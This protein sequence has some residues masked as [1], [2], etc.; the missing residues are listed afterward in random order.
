MASSDRELLALTFMGC[1]IN[2]QLCP[3][4]QYLLVYEQ[5]K[6]VISLVFM[7]FNDLAPADECILLAVIMLK[8]RSVL[9]IALLSDVQLHGIFVCFIGLDI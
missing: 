8:L 4:F 9:F 2:T 5:N 1:F 6:N 7:N 3:R